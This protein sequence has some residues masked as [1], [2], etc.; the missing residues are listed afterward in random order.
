MGRSQEFRVPGRYDRISD[1]CDFI[2]L[3]AEEAGF[4][5]DDIFRIQLACDEAC[6]NVIQHAYGSEDVDDI[7][8][9]WQFDEYAFII[10][11]R[12]KGRS[13]NPKDV[14]MPYIPVSADEIDKLQIGG[15]GMHFMR[16]LMDEIRFFF[17][18]NSG[19]ELVMVKKLPAT[20]ES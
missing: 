6:T 2:A 16:T 12:D 19:N 8:A 18:D 9:K 5:E 10:T 7:W 13:F 17:H 15:L 3:G 20:D 1:I 14:P 4:D 11:I